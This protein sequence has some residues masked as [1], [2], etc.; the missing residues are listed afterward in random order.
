[1]KE[2]KKAKEIT[3]CF[4]EMRLIGIE[5]KWLEPILRTWLR[6]SNGM[7]VVAR[8]EICDFQVRKIGEDVT[9]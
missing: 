2:K 1:M 3:T 5:L 4:V 7:L 9:L 6:K 8:G